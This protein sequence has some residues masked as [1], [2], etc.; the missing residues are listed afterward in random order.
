M[1]RFLL[2]WSFIYNNVF[3]FISFLT[4][5]AWFVKAESRLQPHHLVF[6]FQITF[7]WQQLQIRLKS[8]QNQNSECSLDWTQSGVLGFFFFVLFRQGIPEALSWHLIPHTF[9][10]SYD[11]QEEHFG[12]VVKDNKIM[13]DVMM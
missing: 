9:N 5:H 12:Q 1:C 3:S 8:S 6:K 2:T 4:Y 10:W 11:K 7:S 13:Y